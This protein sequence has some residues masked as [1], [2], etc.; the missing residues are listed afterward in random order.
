M[1]TVNQLAPVQKKPT[2]VK[3]VAQGV[4]LASTYAIATY[5]QAAD[6]LPDLSTLGDTAKTHLTT[7]ASVAFAVF[8]VGVGIVGLF[9]GYANLK[10]G[11]K[12][13]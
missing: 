12:R 5:A 9:K 10:S 6:G 8:V 7:A 13:A 3:R 2:L 11:I 4:M 1:K